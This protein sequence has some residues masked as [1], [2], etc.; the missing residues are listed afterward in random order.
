MLLK[1]FAVVS[2][3]ALMSV[4]AAVGGQAGSTVLQGILSG[5]VEVPKGDP[6]GA[7][8]AKIT[9]NGTQLCWV[10]ETT[11][12]GA[13]TA[14]HIHKGGMRVAGPVVVA[15][16]ASYKP[17]GCVTATVALANAIAKNP[18]AYYV[19]VHNTQYPNGAL[20]GQLVPNE[21]TMR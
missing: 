21:E 1:S 20:R 14:A 2:V 9:I 6:D 13:L 18:K 12:V 3:I 11:K 10:I 8:T 5:K 15:F 19:N 16:G 17:T 4:T 7:G